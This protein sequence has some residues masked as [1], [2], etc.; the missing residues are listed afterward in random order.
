MSPAVPV[1]RPSKKPARKKPAQRKTAAVSSPVAAATAQTKDPEDRMR[2]RSR[3]LQTRPGFLIR[4]LYQIHVALFAEECAAEQI[5]PIQ[6]SVLTALHELGTIDQGTLS[7]A[8]ALDRTNVADVVARLETRRFLK[9][10]ASPTDRRMMLASLT[11]QGRALLKRLEAAATLAHERTIAAL[12]V[13]EKTFFLEA[14]TRLIA[15]SDGLN[16]AS[17]ALKTF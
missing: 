9:R 12:P 10:H 8:V 16:N 6:Y 3:T 13:E 7:R 14:L 15:S 17:I 2:Q 4:R 1:A 11:D 5:T